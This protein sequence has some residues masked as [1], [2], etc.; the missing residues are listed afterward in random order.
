[1]RSAIKWLMDS[2]T[3]YDVEERMVEAAMQERRDRG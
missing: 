2:P 3:C 1:M